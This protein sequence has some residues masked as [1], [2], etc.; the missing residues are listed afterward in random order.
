MYL[1]REDIS[2]LYDIWNTPVITC[3]TAYEKFQPSSSTQKCKMHVWTFLRYIKLKIF[4]HNIL[5]HG[6]NIY[7]YI[8]L[9]VNIHNLGYCKLKKYLYLKTTM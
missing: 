1:I 9:I 3:A 6:I 7:I 8:F 2:F 4:K 5:E